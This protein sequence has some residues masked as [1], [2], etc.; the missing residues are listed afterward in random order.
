M[1]TLAEAIEVYVAGMK[2]GSARPKRRERYK[3]NTIRS[4]E[5]SLRKHIAPSPVAGIKAGE[6][7]PP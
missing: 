6:I 2:D 3:P 5:R 1:G 7:P 4:Y